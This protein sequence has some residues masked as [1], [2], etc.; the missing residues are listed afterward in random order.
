MV[1]TGL[2]KSDQLP[3]SASGDLRPLGE[4]GG[5]L[6]V[7]TASERGV[8]LALRAFAQSGAVDDQTRVFV[9]ELLADRPEVGEVQFLA[10][11]GTDPP[12]G[13]AGRGDANQPTADEA[14]GAGDPGEGRVR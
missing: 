11:E 2:V 7:E 3:G 9:L 10:C 13:R 5:H 4:A 14:A 12:G 8:G 1:E 6:G